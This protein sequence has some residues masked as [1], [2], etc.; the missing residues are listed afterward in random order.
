[1]A[2]FRAHIGTMRVA[3]REAE[4]LARSW[5]AFKNI[6]LY[7]TEH[8]LEEPLTSPVITVSLTTPYS[9]SLVGIVGIVDAQVRALRAHDNFNQSIAEHL[10]IIP[11]QPGT[12][13]METITPNLRVRRTGE[14]S[15]PAMTLSWRGISG[16]AGVWG[17][18]ISVDRGDGQW[19]ELPTGK[20]SR[21]IDMHPQPAQPCTW[22]YRAEYVNEF[23]VTIGVASH[24]SVIA[25]AQQ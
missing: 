24:A 2:N 11:R 8:T 13:N 17:V 10:G 6:A 22:N 12:P 18:R 7:A 25:V 19:H 23:G 21:L 5:R 1:V 20:T 15:T 9:E 4:E 16:L 3:T 14:G